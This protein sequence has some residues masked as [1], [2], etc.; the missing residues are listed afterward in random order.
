MVEDRVS[1]TDANSTFWTELCG[2]TLARSIGVT[3]AS[4]ASLDRFDRWYFDF[5]PYLEKQIDFAALAGKR[6]LEV[7]LGYGSVAQR[8]AAVGAIYQGL[9][10]APGPVAM[11]NHRLKQMG[12]PGEARQGDVL[13][14]PFPDGSFDRVIAI[15]CYH[16]TGDLA[17]AIAETRRVLVP[18][19]QATIMVYGAYSYR[20]WVRWF[21]PT[22]SYLLWD[23]LGIGAWRRTST[24]ERAAYD[25]DT[26]GAAAPETVFVSSSHMR[27]LA[28]EWHRVDIYRRNIGAEFPLSLIPRKYLLAVLGPLTGLDLYCQLTK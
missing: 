26:S 7:G 8:L 1:L 24:A 28:S 12:F 18:G 9:D 23:K 2:T 25:A 21:G 20:R 11:V 17:R 4:P 5:Y 6:V 22:A 10:I 16:H 15:G 19:G 14:C 3:D 13:A 27:R